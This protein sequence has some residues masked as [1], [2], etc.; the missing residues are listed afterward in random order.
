MLG[1]TYS[2][3]PSRPPSSTT[4]SPS[5]RCKGDAM[6]A[7]FCPTQPTP[8]RRDLTRRACERYRH[9]PWHACPCKASSTTFMSTGTFKGKH[10]E[11]RVSSRAPAH[12]PTSDETWRSPRA[13]PVPRTKP[14]RTASRAGRCHCDRTTLPAAS[15]AMFT[16]RFQAG[17]ETCEPRARV[18]TRAVFALWF[19]LSACG[20]ERPFAEGAAPDPLT[21]PARVWLDNGKGC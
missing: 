19:V 16:A 18:A 20:K 17:K 11:P 14:A 8:R 10:S 21:L 5:H 4:R 13:S 15:A 2:H 9:A 3:Q 1:Q 6:A 12:P 7:T